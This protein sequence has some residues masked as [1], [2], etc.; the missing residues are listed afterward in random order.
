M[1]SIE[2]LIETSSIPQVVAVES[3]FLPRTDCR[4]DVIASTDPASVERRSVANAT[5]GRARRLHRPR[6]G[7]TTTDQLASRC[8]H[9]RGVG[10]ERV[11]FVVGLVADQ[12]ALHRRGVGGG[13]RT[14]NPRVSGDFDGHLVTPL[15]LVVAFVR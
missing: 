4:C 12:S 11:W 7:G 1:I 3:S 13:D 10:G 5:S 8:F 2:R 9:R 14:C 6:V 15:C